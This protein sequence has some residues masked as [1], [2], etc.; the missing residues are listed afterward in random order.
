MANVPNPDRSTPLIFKPLWALALLLALPAPPVQADV[1]MP[2][3]KS[4]PPRYR[5]STGH[6]GPYCAPPLPKC[7]KGF[8]PRVIRAHAYC[9]PPPARPC[10]VGSFWTSNSATDTYCKGGRRCDGYPCY[11]KGYTC[12]ETSLCVREVRQWRGRV[13]ERVLG[14]C[15]TDADCKGAVGVKCVQAKRCDPPVKLGPKAGAQKTDAPAKKADAPAKKTEAPPQKTDAP[16][17]KTDAPAKKADAPAKKI[18]PPAKPPAPPV[19][20]KKS[21]CAVAGAADAWPLILLLLLAA[22]FRRRR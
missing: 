9:E 20:A 21:D 7:K 22:R 5:P 10:P 19:K 14:P 16:A 11:G 15:K 13:M 6:G 17:Q 1:V 12:R 3:P 2:P 18:D 8:R 4:C